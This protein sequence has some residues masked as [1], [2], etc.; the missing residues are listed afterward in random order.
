MKNFKELVMRNTEA[1][2]SDEMYKA[3]GLSK[4]RL[5]TFTNNA[6]DS[7]MRDSEQV[8]EVMQRYIS[9]NPAAIGAIVDDIIDSGD[10]EIVKN[11]LGC[12]VKKDCFI[13][14]QTLEINY[15][16]WRPQ[17]HLNI[18]ESNEKNK[19]TLDIYGWINRNPVSGNIE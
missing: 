17:Q 6:V 5:D 8:K 13:D 2:S 3:K 14:H 9:S 15:N 12:G 18:S 4:E 10:E 11:A 19:N 7:I 1:Y 16:L